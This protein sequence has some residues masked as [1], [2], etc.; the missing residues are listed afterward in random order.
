[1]RSP[2]AMRPLG[3]ATRHLGWVALGF[4]AMLLALGLVLARVGAHRILDTA[5][6]YGILT[7]GEQSIG[8]D[9]RIT[10]ERVKFIPHG[11]DESGAIRAKR[12]SI[13]TGGPVWLMRGALR[14]TP[15]DRLERRRKEL[16]AARSLEQ[17][18]APAVLPAA[19]ALTIVAEGVS[20]GPRAAPALWLPWLDPSNGVLFAALGC[21]AIPDFSTAIATRAGDSGSLDVRVHLKQRAGV[22]NANAEFAFGGISTAVWQA[23]LL[24][25]SKHGL[26]ASD[27]RQWQ[28]VEQQWMLRDRGFVRARNRECARRLALPRPQ[29]VARHALAV[30]RQMAAWK[31]ALPA[32]LEQAYREHASLG[33]EIV[34]VS[35][36]KRPLRLGEYQLM[37]RSQRVGALDA[38]ITVAGRR[39]PL[40]LEFLPDD[41]Q[42]SD[43]AA[44]ADPADPA[45]PALGVVASPAGAAPDTRA[46]PVPARSEAPAG[47]AVVAVENP[48]TRPVK[49]ILAMKV[50][51]AAPVTGPEVPAVASRAAGRADVAPPASSTASGS[52]A[53]PVA[54]AAKL[55]SQ[56]QYHGLVGRQVVVTTTLGTSRTGRIK[57]ANSVALTLEMQSSQGPIQLRIPAEQIVRVRAVR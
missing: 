51:G 12:V 10:L 37:S 42:V 46:M 13:D 32:P 55:P 45:A 34:F 33:G 35:K 19:V 57:I 49:A 36:P 54:S 43:V 28:L 47:R 44:I 4:F 52:L 29:F 15:A 14:R 18:N 26:L 9:G 5:R 27:W 24:P 22:A 30:K 38:D 6:W 2:F 56:G 8:W 17:S 41:A 20:M 53:A 25:P 31:I 40:L 16:E 11:S 21:G 7:A 3:I 23:R 1:M 48:G 50:P 39:L